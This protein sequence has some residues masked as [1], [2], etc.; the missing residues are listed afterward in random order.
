MQAFTVKREEEIV[1]VHGEKIRIDQPQ[2][3][4]GT[5]KSKGN[6]FVRE[7]NFATGQGV[8]V[9]AS[10]VGPGSK[11][12]RTASKWDS[13]KRNTARNLIDD[14]GGGPVPDLTSALLRVFVGNRSP[15]EEWKRQTRHGTGRASQSADVIPLRFLA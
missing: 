2:R 13:G 12:T 7:R 5:K 8:L 10:S 14:P 11:D 1:S 6:H 4:E 9:P 3:H 15:G